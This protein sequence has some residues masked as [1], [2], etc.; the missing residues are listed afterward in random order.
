M[1][2]ETIRWQTPLAYMRRTAKQD[3]VLG[4]KQIKKGDKVLMWYVSGNRDE[5]HFENPDDYISTGRTCAATFHSAT[6]FIVAWATGLAKCSCEYSGKK[7][8]RASTA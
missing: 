8:S 5:S 6:A 4:G 3:T 2:S 1:V 7:S